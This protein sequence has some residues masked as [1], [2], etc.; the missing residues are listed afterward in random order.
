MFLELGPV[1]LLLASIG[2]IEQN[3]QDTTP[4]N[5]PRILLA[6]SIDE[7]GNLEL[8]SYQTIYIGF[9]GDSYNARSTHKYSLESVLI[10]DLAGNRITTDAAR[11]RF[12]MGEAPIL[13]TSYGRK[14]DDHYRSLF[15]DETLVFVFPKKAPEWKEIE[16]PTATVRN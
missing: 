8:V 11:V 15:N 9:R 6:T 4:D 7:A 14:V 16:D 10:F 5:P 12:G 1:V 3:S 2:Y 13:A